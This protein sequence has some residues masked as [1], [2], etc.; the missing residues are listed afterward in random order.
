MILRSILLAAVLAVPAAA[1]APEAPAPAAQVSSPAAPPRRGNR[2]L[3]FY[4]PQILLGVC[5]LAAASEAAARRSPE[6]GRAL[7]VAWDWALLAAFG[8]CAALGLL[9]LFPLDRALKGA[10]E[11][12]HVWAGAAATAAAGYH[13]VKRIRTFI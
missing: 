6:R 8:A 2:L 5:A 3:A 13:A 1:Q 9:L 4:V 10:V 12:A 11:H 7:R